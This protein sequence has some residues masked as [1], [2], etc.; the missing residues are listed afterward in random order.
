MLIIHDHPC[1]PCKVEHDPI[2]TS[3][4]Y[5]CRCG[6]LMI[7]RKCSLSDTVVFGDHY[8]MNVNGQMVEP[9]YIEF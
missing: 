8:L 1:E 4:T 5:D 7:V 6:K 3:F 2:A 9:S